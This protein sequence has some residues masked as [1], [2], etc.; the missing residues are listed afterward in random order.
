MIHSLE[1]QRK[2]E[3]YYDKKMFEHSGPEWGWGLYYGYNDH[4]NPCSDKEAYF[5]SS[6]KA[7]ILR[8]YPNRIFSS[9]LIILTHYPFKP[10]FRI[11]YDRLG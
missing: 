9:K 10:P 1:F 5:I 11:L 4:L 2:C 3:F 8:R 7:K 6:N